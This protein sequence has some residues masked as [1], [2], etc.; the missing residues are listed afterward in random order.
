MGTG[1]ASRH[2]PPS[3]VVSRRPY[4]REGLRPRSSG[5]LPKCVTAMGPLRGEWSSAA[6]SGDLACEAGEGGRAKPVGVADRSNVSRLCP[7]EDT[8]VMRRMIVTLATAA[9][10]PAITS[11]FDRLGL[12]PQLIEHPA[13]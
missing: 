10:D 13:V 1:G 7:S 9:D 4:P 11:L 12:T 2:I 8:S 3:V 5:Q 6:P